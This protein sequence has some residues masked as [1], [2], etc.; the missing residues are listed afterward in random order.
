MA[1]FRKLADAAV[2]H[3]C[4][5]MRLSCHAAALAA[6]LVSRFGLCCEPDVAGQRFQQEDFS[7]AVERF[8]ECDLTSLS[9]EQLEQFGYSVFMAYVL[10]D[11]DRANREAQRLFEFSARRGYLDSI[12][13]LAEFVYGDEE[14]GIPAEPFKARCLEGVAERAITDDFAN[15]NEVASCLEQRNCSAIDSQLIYCPAPAA[16]LATEL[17]EADLL[18]EFTIQVN[19]SAQD[20]DI[21]SSI[22]DSRWIDAAKNALSSWQYLDVS[23]PVRETQRFQIRLSSE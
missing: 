9:G 4:P 1:R 14:L 5:M 3:G 11:V 23:I 22:G 15:P 19:G 20:I 16:P 6:V 12:E 17:G 18:F 8:S 2:A 21:V 7:A 10:D 13:S